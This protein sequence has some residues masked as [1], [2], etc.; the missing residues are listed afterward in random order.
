MQVIARILL[1]PLVL[2]AFN[3]DASCINNQYGKVVCGEGQCRTDDHGKVFCARAG[4]AVL[5]KFS[6][7]KCGVGKCAMDYLDKIWCSKKPGGGAEV[8][9]HGKV[10]C[11][12]GC[13]EASASLC[14][15]AK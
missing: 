2:C 3:V 14:Q 15:Q 7:V 12:G 1:L 5:D 13:A 6:K 9:S 4:G 11:L 8:D 10:V